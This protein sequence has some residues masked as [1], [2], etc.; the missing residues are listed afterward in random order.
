MI[1]RAFSH[2]A[3]QTVKLLTSTLSKFS[4]C[5]D[6][7]SY[8]K[9]LKALVRSFTAMLVSKKMYPKI[10]CWNCWKHCKFD[11]TGRRLELVLC[12]LGGPTQAQTAQKHHSAFCKNLLWWWWCNRKDIAL[13]VSGLEPQSALALL[14][15]A[16]YPHQRFSQILETEIGM[17]Q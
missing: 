11:G 12:W 9:K 14:L 1:F 6:G 2:L 13:S 16:I 4:R 7:K 3:A 15:H 10:R 5:K 8:K 17:R